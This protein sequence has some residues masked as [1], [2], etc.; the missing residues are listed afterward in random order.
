MRPD[1]Y[2]IR[3]LSTCNSRGKEVGEVSYRSYGLTTADMVRSAEGIYH[4]HKK[5]GNRWEGTSLEEL[6]VCQQHIRSSPLIEIHN[7]HPNTTQLALRSDL[8]V[9]LAVNKTSI[10]YLSSGLSV[11]FTSLTYGRCLNLICPRREALI[12]CRR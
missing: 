2:V 6:D 3:R 12:V 11:S 5:A 4:H 10:I 1:D 7:N 9:L 8:S